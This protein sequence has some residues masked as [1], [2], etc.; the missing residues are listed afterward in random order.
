MSDSEIEKTGESANKEETKTEDEQIDEK[1][2]KS[3]ESKT[4][5][6][7]DWEL[8]DPE[9]DNTES[10][11]E[12]KDEKKTEE[13]STVE[14][15]SVKDDN[16]E[17]KHAKEV[18]DGVEEGVEDVIVDSP[19][20]ANLESKVLNHPLEDDTK[21]DADEPA[22]E[23]DVDTEPMGKDIE[24]TDVPME[25]VKEQDSTGEAEKAEETGQTA[26]DEDKQI[27]ET[28]TDKDQSKDNLE[29]KEEEKEVKEEEKEAKE[30]EKEAKKEEIE[31]KKE[32]I[33]AKEEVKEEMPP[34]D[35][36]T[37]PN[38]GDV[39]LLQSEVL[40]ERVKLRKRIGGA[41][42]RR[43]PTKRAS[44]TDG[45]GRPVSWMFADSAEPKLVD[46]EF[47]TDEEEEKEAEDRK[48]EVHSPP[49]PRIPIGGVA[50]PMMLPG[51]ADAVKFRK[52]A[53]ARHAREFGNASSKSN[54]N[55]EVKSP[56][57]A[58]NVLKSPS[59]DGG[60]N[61]VGGLSPSWASGS[62]FKQ[63]KP[64]KEIPDKRP[65]PA[66]RPRPKPRPK[67][68]AVMSDI[69]GQSMLISEEL[70]QKVNKQSIKRKDEE[71]K[72]D[73]VIETEKKIVN[74]EQNNKSP[75]SVIIK[76]PSVEEK[77]QS[78]SPVLEKKLNS[79]IINSQKKMED[80]KEKEDAPKTPQWLDQKKKLPPIPKNK[81]KPAA[82]PVKPDKPA[83]SEQPQWKQALIMKKKED[84]AQG[85]TKPLV[86]PQRKANP[87]APVITTLPDWKQDLADRNKKK[88]NDSE[89]TSEKGDEEKNGKEK[90]PE[91][92]RQA[93]ER[94]QRRKKLENANPPS[95][96]NKEQSGNI[97]QWKREL[98]ER[99]QRTRSVGEEPNKKAKHISSEIIPKDSSPSVPSWK[100]ELERR[101]Q[102]RLQKTYKS[103][104]HV[105]E[106]F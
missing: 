9:D 22:K 53:P 2:E 24:N 49:K 85:K 42:G 105:E 16:S 51:L 67:S 96:N 35:E 65:K 103:V 5:T 43:P 52:K 10:N 104:E 19:S 60:F 41:A 31:A 33:E 30:E 80:K 69:H 88:R 15:D 11:E 86:V 26:V 29:T 75:V 1:E 58:K 72:T 99:K 18:M 6:E 12:L 50:S 91:W 64:A 21:K 89:S 77:P 56:P 97:P 62:A 94:A 37:L 23:Q 101:K 79:D 44:W 93:A 48:E 74:N 63:S 55:T 28:E 32:E 71:K 66:V 100:A 61:K 90:V 83:A 27:E 78:P 36:V 102:A 38:L 95:N 40:M 4:D 39:Q 54:E 46:Q 59:N 70:L 76:T 14:V 13:S 47:S 92:K 98:M 34:T 106:T 57:W 17:E 68:I 45:Q 8:L 7:D 82:R 20:D 81:P 87:N 25:P 3:N 84:E 73:P